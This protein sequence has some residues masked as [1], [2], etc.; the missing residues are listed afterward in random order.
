MVARSRKKH[1][2]WTAKTLKGITRNGFKISTQFFFFDFL[3]T[4]L[5]NILWAFL[6]LCEN[7]EAK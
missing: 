4:F 1:L 3:I 7:F 6:Q 2:F 5:I